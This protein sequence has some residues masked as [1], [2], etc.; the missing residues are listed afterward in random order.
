MRQLFYLL[1]LTSSLVGCSPESESG[2]TIDFCESS[3]ASDSCANSGNTFQLGTPVYVHFTSDT[4][5]KDTT[6][7]GRIVR[8]TDGGGEFEL[9]L[10][11]FDIEP[12]T[13]ILIQSIPFQNFGHNALGTFLIEFSGEDGQILAERELVIVE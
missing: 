10:R 3:T 7:I 13:T 12:E 6:I 4:P 5:F 2:L 9:G 8:K 1:L 11:Q